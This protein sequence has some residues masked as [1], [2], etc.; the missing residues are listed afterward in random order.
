[1][2]LSSSCCWLWVV[3]PRKCRWIF[4]ISLGT[5]SA[6]VLKGTAC[7]WEMMAGRFGPWKPRVSTCIFY[8]LAVMPPL[9]QVSEK[10]LRGV[11]DTLDDIPNSQ[12]GWDCVYWRR[13]S[14]SKWVW[15]QYWRCDCCH[16]KSLMCPVWRQRFQVIL[17]RK[18][19]SA[20]WE[21]PLGHR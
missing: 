9:S 7:L 16:L 17:W 13:V 11:N 1:M 4:C 10:M 8:T 15:D 18:M 14:P 3:L 19:R 5:L 20:L 6:F 2:T 12:W 21:L